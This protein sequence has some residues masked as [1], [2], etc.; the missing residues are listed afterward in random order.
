VELSI[1]LVVRLAGNRRAEAVKILEASGLQLTTAS[2]MKDGA[3][4]IVEACS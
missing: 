3:M 1:P 4:K 2:D